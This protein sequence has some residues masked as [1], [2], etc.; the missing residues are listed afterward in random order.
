MNFLSVVE[1]LDETV[2]I[3]KFFK[4]K[5]SKLCILMRVYIK[6][7]KS[8]VINNIEHMTSLPRY[9]NKS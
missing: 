9:L 2:Y 8:D 6:V 3:S 7:R 4:L 1:K 5:M